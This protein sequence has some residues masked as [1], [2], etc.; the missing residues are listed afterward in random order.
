MEDMSGTL[1]NHFNQ[2]SV[3]DC[4]ECSHGA[5]LEIFIIH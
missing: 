1:E 2:I 5:F 3:L 4:L